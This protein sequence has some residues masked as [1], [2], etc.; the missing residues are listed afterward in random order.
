[1]VTISS[2]S[3][4]FVFAVV[5]ITS[6]ICEPFKNGNFCYTK[7]AT[8]LTSGVAKLVPELFIVSSVSIFSPSS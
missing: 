6:A 2:G 1:M 4:T 7:A 8:P 5:K 3:V